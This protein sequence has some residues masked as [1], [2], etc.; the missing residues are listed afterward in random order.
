MIDANELLSTK[1]SGI[2]KFLSQ[3][4]MCDPIFLKHESENKPNDYSKGSSRI[5]YF[6]GTH[7]ITQF[8]TR[9][10][11]SSFDVVTK[12]DHRILYIDLKLRYFLYDPYQIIQAP[13]IRRLQTTYTKGVLKYK[14][15]LLNNIKD[16]NT[17]PSMQIIHIEILTK[18]LSL[19]DM[20]LINSID[21]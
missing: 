17:L 3:T 21:K 15:K 18:T 9:C 20:V 2:S 5:D 19:D 16:N 6:F 4:H 14:E 10:G 1:N 8:M 13:I 7:T 12:T 11:I